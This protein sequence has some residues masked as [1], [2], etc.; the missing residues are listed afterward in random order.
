M[1]KWLCLAVAVI[2]LV[3]LGW[4]VNDIRLQVRQSSQMVQ[5]TGR[6]VNEHLPII[7]EKSR[8]STDLV[9]EHLPTI[10]EKTCATT[11]T[12]AELTEDIRQLKELLGVAHTARD[13][14][15]VAYADSV[16]KSIEASGGT[17]G[18]KKSLGGSGL[19]HPV[20][21]RE[22]AVGARKEAVYLTVVAKSKKELVTRLANNWLGS[23]WYIQVEGKDPVKLLDWLKLHHAA[24]EELW[25]EK[26]T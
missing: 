8:A 17:M 14:N 11:E 21:A 7:V 5:D 26:A 4:M 18:L 2:F 9:A 16:L 10:V 1:F 25:G 3:V 24:T 22:W 23:P 6:T 12:L 13:Q 20:P 19:K 15:L